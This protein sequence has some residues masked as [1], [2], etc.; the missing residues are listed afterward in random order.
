MKLLDMWA[1]AAQRWKSRSELLEKMPEDIQAVLFPANELEWIKREDK[2]AER[3]NY[4]AVTN[5]NALIQELLREI[6]D[7]QLS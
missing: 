7:L 2:W 5:N 6:Y 4:Y 1:S 3:A